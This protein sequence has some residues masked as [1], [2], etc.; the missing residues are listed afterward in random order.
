MLLRYYTQVND[1]MPEPLR[2]MFR[3]A[4]GA[5]HEEAVMTMWDRLQEEGEIKGLAKGKAEGKAEAVLAV[6]S[7][8]GISIPDEVRTRVLACHDVVLL[9]R[10]I[11]RASTATSIAEAISD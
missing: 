2:K 9:E 6:L 7:A 4:A 8:R 1:G 10:W 11:V 3:E 5:Q